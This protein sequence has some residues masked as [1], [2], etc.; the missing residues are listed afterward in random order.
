VQA[1]SVH[2]FGAWIVIVVGLAACGVLMFR[3]FWQGRAD[4]ANVPRWTWL[5]V[6]A[7]TTVAIYRQQG[8]AWAIA[9]PLAGL[10]VG[11]VIRAWLIRHPRRED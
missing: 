6:V 3:L 1:D 4:W 7:V 2:A 8:L 5:L 9:V 11:L 10:V